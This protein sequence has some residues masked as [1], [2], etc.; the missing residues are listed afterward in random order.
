MRT[1]LHGLRMTCLHGLWCGELG[2]RGLELV[3]V[4]AKKKK[5]K[6][7]VG[8]CRRGLGGRCWHGCV[9]CMGTCCCADDSVKGLYTGHVRTGYEETRQVK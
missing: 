8:D 2:S 5:R 1:C 4:T 3:V 7:Q 6:R 9:S